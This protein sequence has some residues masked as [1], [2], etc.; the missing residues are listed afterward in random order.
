MKLKSCVEGNYLNGSHRQKTSIR[1][2]RVCSQK[3]DKL[4]HGLVAHAN[5]TYSHFNSIQPDD[6]GDGET[7]SLELIPC[8]VEKKKNTK[9]VSANCG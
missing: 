4:R 3:P 9:V 5:L 8:A 1:R 6:L 2:P 7:I